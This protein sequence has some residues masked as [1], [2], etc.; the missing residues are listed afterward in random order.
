M[1]EAAASAVYHM[2]ADG[3]GLRQAARSLGVAPTTIKRRQ[4]WLGKQCLLQ[5]ESMMRRFRLNEPVA[6]DG[7]RTFAG[8]QHEVAELNTW[9]AVR[10]GLHL[11]LDAIPLR[12]SGRMT[13]AQR[14]QRAR[15]EQRLGRPDPRA[16]ERITARGL[17]RILG[18]LPREET[19]ELISDDEPAYAR[20]TRSVCIATGRS[21]AHLT[22]SARRRRDA[23]NPLWRINHLH[24]FQ[25]HSLANLK[26]E[27]IAHSKDLA[28]LL[29][30]A[31]IHRTFANVTKGVSERTAERSR[32]TPAM[33]AGLEARPQHGQR[34]FRWRRFPAHVELGRALRAVYERRVRSRPREDT[35]PDLPKFKS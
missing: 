2:I 12:R 15:R 11:E 33:R 16:R 24:R 35:R 7:M 30:R 5:H 18:L 22:V 9:V 6:V 26:R 13:A 14:R 29:D 19:L 28:G 34:L 17:R 32:I 25:R 31:L 4:R 23:S 3:K 27:T 20:A 1:D 21:V 10:S 8:S